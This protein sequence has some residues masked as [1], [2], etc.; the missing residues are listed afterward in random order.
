MAAKLMYRWC[1]LLR[2]STPLCV[3]ANV[4]SAGG[5]MM[6]T[7]VSSQTP[8]AS[9]T[10]SSFS[11]Q[12]DKL[13]FNEPVY[14]TQPERSELDNLIGTAS[15]AE[16]LLRLGELSPVNGNQAAMIIIRLSRIVGE[17]KLE[18]GSVLEDARFQHLLQT[19][20]NQLS[21]V[22]NTALVNL[23]KSLYLLGLERSRQ[24]LRSVEQEVRWRLRRLTFKHMASL[25]EH[26]ATGVP[27]GEQNN[28]LSD[29]VK[30][31][32]LRWTEIED[33]RTVGALMTKVG[34]LSPTLM[35]R[36][37]DKGLELAEQFSPEDTR[38]V[39]VA[40]AVQNR[41]S[42]PLLRAL[43]YHLVQK[44]FALNTNI[45]LDLAFAF[46]KLNFHQTQVFQK[47]ALDLHPRVPEMVPGDVVRCVKSFAYLKWLNLPL[48][49][50]FA[51]YLLDNVD[52]FT[53]LQLSNI[54][55]AFAR[56]NFQPTNGEAF[57]SMIHT[58]LDDQLDTFDPYMLLDLVW[59]L[60][61][62]QQAKAAH[63][64]KV[65]V[66]EFHT[67]FFGDESTKGQNYQ[68]KLIHV[69]TTAQLECADYQ[70]PFLPP[71]ALG[72]KELQGDRKAT[73][74]QSSLRE[75]LKGLV[76][77]EA[78]VR[79]SVDTIYGW[80]L[81]AEMILNSDNQPLPVA[82]FEAPHLAQS[83]GSQS[84]PSGARRLA[85]LR[86]EFPNFSNRSK[87]LLGRFVLARRHLQ[88]AGFV[89]A[90][91][92]YYEWLDLKSEWQKAAYLRDK[93]SKAVAEEMA[94]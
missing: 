50:A 41:R 91:V 77:E 76:G 49:E 48:F 12:T 40:L 92:P 9:L 68:L 16:D 71:E 2:V 1:R 11:R 79:F 51:Q 23:L 45:L 52:R 72:T 33:T 59:S 15:T 63:L 53:P 43:S 46:G 61:V 36:L 93:M 94:K 20:H 26:V 13:S 24:E 35:D 10:V 60:C 80:Q 89:I 34:G 14:R 8:L 58:R 78:K 31:L 82:G 73:L 21:Q 75:V 18:P 54:V 30:H 86:W 70:G 7:R 90:D 67:H 84:L 62:L 55:L 88:G 32:E 56:L 74:L 85:F 4:S 6:I 39:A 57:Y 25:A 29:L 19:V 42:I 81:D 17:Q 22:W 87:D 27:K 38:K 66:P 37:E 44:H 83:T 64:H 47:I 3:Q 28:L 65:L 5:M 69:N